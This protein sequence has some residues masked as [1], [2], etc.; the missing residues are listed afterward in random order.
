[1]AV[2]IRVITHYL[3]EFRV[4]MQYY[5]GHNIISV[6]TAEGHLTPNKLVFTSTASSS[7]ME[8]PVSALKNRKTVLVG[9]RSMF[10]IKN[11]LNNQCV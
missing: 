7:P 2:T 5:D 4:L 3:Y 8:P 10:A 11:T 6:A 1:M 9:Q